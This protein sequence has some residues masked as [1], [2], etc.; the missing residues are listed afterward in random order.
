MKEMA[1]APS[2][3]TSSWFLLALVGC[4]GIGVMGGGALNAGA[5]P[6]VMDIA[7]HVD[8][9]R[10]AINSIN[11]PGQPQGASASL[12]RI[13]KPGSYY[14]PGN[15]TGLAGCSG[16]EITASGVTIDLM[17]FE[18]AGVPGSRD[19]IECNAGNGIR[20][21][22]IRNGTIRSW[23]EDGIDLYTTSATNCRIERIRAFSN[24]NRGIAA[25]QFGI[26]RDCVS[27]HNLEH[28]ITAGPGTLITGC[29]SH[30]NLQDGICVAGGSSIIDCIAMDNHG[31]AFVARGDSLVRGN[32][33]CG[34]IKGPRMGT[35]I[36]VQ[37]NNNRIEGNSC[38]LHLKGVEVVNQGNFIVNN[39]CSDNETNWIIHRGN[40]FGTI[41]N[42]R[43]VAHPQ[44]VK[45]DAATGTLPADARGV[46]NW[47]Y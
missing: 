44:D 42:M 43:D 24:N 33:S 46:A 41:Y 28:G 40:A 4:C 29:A 19:G 16:I 15:V 30:M 17:G 2:L 32:V 34:V 21:I 47:T 5:P 12:F 7:P 22:E 35:G 13:T 10:I 11:T 18:F 23:G 27:T 31:H 8:E 1:T 45:G 20:G 3:R 26:V 6:E 14:L 39:T 37:G 25:G 9:C 38:S 36:L